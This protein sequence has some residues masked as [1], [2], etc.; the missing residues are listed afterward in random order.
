MREIAAF[1]FESLPGW[2]FTLT[3]FITSETDDTGH[4]GA[5]GL[6]LDYHQDGETCFGC[7]ADGPVGQ[8]DMDRPFVPGGKVD[9]R[10]RSL[11]GYTIWVTRLERQVTGV[12]PCAPARGTLTHPEGWLQIGYSRDGEDDNVNICGTWGPRAETEVLG[13]V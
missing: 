7:N 9:I 5:G 11:P 4:H 1:K 13:R 10:F 8:P 2:T 6:R 3:R 12:D